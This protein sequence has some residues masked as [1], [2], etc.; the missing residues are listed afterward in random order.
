MTT[1]FLNC[2]ANTLRTADLSTRAAAAAD[3]GFAGIGLRVTDY[4]EA[5]MTDAEIRDV[6]DRHDLQVLELEHNWDWA[7]GED[8]V[9][10]AMFDFA[11]EI[12]IRHINVPMFEDHPLADL[13]EPFGALCDRAAEHDVLIG[14]EFLPYSHVRTIGEA[15]E[16]VEAAG[17]PNGGVTVDLW[18]W[19]RSDARAEDLAG[20]PASVITT[21]QLCD[22]APEPGRDMTEEARHNRLLPGRGAGNT[23]GTLRALRD[24]GVAAPVSVEVFSDDLD[25]HP[26]AE[27]AGLAF[28]AG[29]ATL[30]AAGFDAP[31]WIT[32]HDTTQG[33]AR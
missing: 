22:V 15:W 5:N 8:P 17:R 24:H 3:A 21:V 1:R 25:A 11:D 28:D 20:I 27:A 26:P 31:T 29:V 6:L 2:S 30:E 32:T 16:V 9:E 13:I 14:F 7:L 19:F 33:E 23:L 10:R 4:L 18:H 12:G